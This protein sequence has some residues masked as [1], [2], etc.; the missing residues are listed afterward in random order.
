MHPIAAPSEPNSVFFFFVLFAWSV[1]A[2]AIDVFGAYLMA[3]MAIRRLTFKIFMAAMEL[4][5]G[6]LS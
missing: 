1:H 3:Q 5:V 4:S 6:M 2:R